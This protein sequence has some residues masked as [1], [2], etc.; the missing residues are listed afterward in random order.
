MQCHVS[1]VCVC[2]AIVIELSIDWT[3]CMIKAYCVSPVISSYLKKQNS[4]WECSGCS[5]FHNSNICQL[6][7]EYETG[8]NHNITQ[9][10]MT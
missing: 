8:Q 3:R 10:W 7:V 5:A 4:F 9:A 2:A 6:T 1:W